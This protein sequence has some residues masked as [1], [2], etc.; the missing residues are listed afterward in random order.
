MPCNV[1]WLTFRIYTG[2]FSYNF[3][4]C[5]KLKRF[6]N[7][8]LIQRPTWQSKCFNEFVYLQTIL[9]VGSCIAYSCKQLESVIKRAQYCVRT[10]AGHFERIS[11]R[12]A[13][14]VCQC[15]IVFARRIQKRFYEFNTF[16]QFCYF[17]WTICSDID[18][19]NN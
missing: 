19:D 18:E 15:L 3:Y 17:I 16:V 11:R 8:W 7:R 2:Q 6:G 4:T 14:T 9:R 5:K 1:L 13:D 10:Q 12:Y